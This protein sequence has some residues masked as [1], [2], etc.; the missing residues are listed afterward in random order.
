MP[1]GK[2]NAFFDVSCDSKQCIGH[3][4]FGCALQV[5]LLWTAFN[6]SGINTR[7]LIGL[8]FVGVAFRVNE[9]YREKRAFF[10]ICGQQVLVCAVSGTSVA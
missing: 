10:F 3:I 9:F 5:N 7:D 4:G 2:G 6:D 1:C 8:G